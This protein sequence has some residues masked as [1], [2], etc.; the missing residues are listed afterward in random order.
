MGGRLWVTWEKQRRNR[1]LSAALDAELC[2]FTYKL[3]RILKYPLFIIL[4]VVKVVSVWPSMLFVQNPSI[5]LSFV[6]VFFGKLLRI[7]VVVDAHNSGVF[8][9]G[10]KHPWATSTLPCL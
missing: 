7:P 3:P 6:S 8:P 10:G 2:E 9:F 4:T 1:T 5:V